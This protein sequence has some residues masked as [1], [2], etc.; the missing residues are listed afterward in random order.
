MNI[1]LAHEWLTNYAGSE[2]VIENIK[3]IYKEAPI[4][5]TVYNPDNLPKEL[6]NID[7]RTTFLQK[8]KKARTNHRMFLPFMPLAWEQFNFNEYDVVLSSSHSCAK[9]IIAP[10]STM[11]VCY[12]HSPMRYAWEF[13][14]EYLERENVGKIKKIL[15]PL[16]MNYIRMWDAISAN[17]VDYFIANSK[18][19]AKRIWKHYRREADV[20][21][22]PVKTSY[23]NI[24]DKDEE[25]FLIVGRLVA[26]KQVD[27]AI[28]A[29]N[30]LG[31]PLVVIGSGPQFDYIKSIAKS[32][33]KI[34][35]RQPDEVIRDYYAKCRAF[36][37]P[38]EEDFGITPLEAQASGRPVVAFGKGGAL[39]TVV[40]NETGLFFAE[41]TIESLKDAIQ[42]FNHLNFD[43]LKIR[44]NALKFDEEIFKKKIKG[45]I[46]E[47]YI[48][49][50]SEM[51]K[52][53]NVI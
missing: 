12:C 22:P 52:K 27:L 5:T 50:N 34:L 30:E 43:K 19:V 36:I 47:K 38:G 41:Q 1:A 42:K 3:E 15:I 18:N 37:F 46:D 24:Q 32:N 26:Y 10:P 39:E 53:G 4:Y 40:E 29:F 2:K 17:R 20:I 9:G 11:H 35:G 33:I 8:Y 6:K 49:F 7:V 31:L 16:I 25:F 21:H 45:Y 23:F 14:W 51:S 13:Y 28:E 48:E 44:E